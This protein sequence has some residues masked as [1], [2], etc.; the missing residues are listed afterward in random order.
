[1]NQKN[2]PPADFL[3]ALRSLREA[4]MSSDFSY[5]EVPAP[6]NIAPF[7]AALSLQTRENSDHPT[8]GRFLVFYNPEWVEEWQGNF[9]IVMMIS[10]VTDDEIAADPVI[11]QVAWDWLHEALDGSGAGAS[12]LSGTVT[13]ESSQSFGALRPQ[14]PVS[15]ID[16]RASWTPASTDLAPHLEAWGILATFCEGDEPTSPLYPVRDLRS[17]HHHV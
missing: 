12:N 11:K 4:R 7:S 16:M 15:N 13:I 3:S 9:R 1:M 5:E 6:R 14:A 2:M 8:H 10:A 17:T